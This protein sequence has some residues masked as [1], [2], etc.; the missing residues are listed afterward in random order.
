MTIRSMPPASSHLAESPVPAPPPTIG[1][2]RATMARN[3]LRRSARSNRGMGHLTPPPA[4]ARASDQRAERGDGRRR[5][6]GF[7]DVAPQSYELPIAGLAYRPIERAEQRGVG[8]GIPEWL[9]RRVERGDAAFRQKESH[10]PVHRVEAFADPAADAVVLF[11]AR[12]HQ[13]DLRIVN[14]L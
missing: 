10:R 11:R 3:F 4:G 14:V 2:P 1:S 7:V 8:F 9:P 12:A 6:F 5:E 13:R